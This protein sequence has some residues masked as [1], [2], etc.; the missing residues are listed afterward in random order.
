M[1]VADTVRAVAIA[2]LDT[3]ILLHRTAF[4]H[5]ALVALVEGTGAVFFGGAQPGA[6][7][8]VVPPR[9]LPA[10]V[11]AQ[12]ARASFVRLVGPPVGGALLGLGRAVPFFVDAASYVFSIVSLLAMRTPFQEPREL[13]R[14]PLRTQI[15]EGFRF[16]WGQPFLR[17]AAFI[18]GLGNFA[19]PGVLLAIVVIGKRHGL[20]GGQIGVLLA[21]FGACTLLGSAVSPLFRRA[22]SM[23]TILLLEL[24]AWLGTIAFLIR[25]NVYVLT[26]SVLPLAVTLPVTD[27]VVDGYRVAITPDRILAAWKV[28]GAASRCS[29]RHSARLSPV[30]CSNPYRRARPLPYSPPAALC[31]RFGERSVRRSARLRASTSSA[32]DCD[33]RTGAEVQDEPRDRPAVE[34]DAA[35]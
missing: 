30:S 11:A 9:Q 4:W 8:A 21:V 31:S 34:P 26:A 25:P 28:F 24:W 29:S 14:S 5:V 20:S 10:A 3:T 2:S 23:R 17:T 33:G 32:N 27:S 16:L 22:L 1:I 12:G 13:D 18:Y 6:L 7:R 19:I 15:A 35:V